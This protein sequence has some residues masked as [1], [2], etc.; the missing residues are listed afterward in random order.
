MPKRSHGSGEL[1]S[2]NLV[3]QVGAKCSNWE[4]NLLHWQH[5]SWH[6]KIAEALSSL[7]LLRPC[8]VQASKTPVHNWGS[9]KANISE[10]SLCRY[11]TWLCYPAVFLLWKRQ[12]LIKGRFVTKQCIFAG[13]V[14]T[15]PSAQCALD[16]CHLIPNLLTQVAD[17]TQGASPW[18]KAHFIPFCFPDLS[19]ASFL[20]VNLWMSFW[21]LCG[22]WDIVALQLLSWRLCFSY[23]PK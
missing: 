13:N 18:T 1:Q 21:S 17:P 2:R 3:A 15:S 22:S 19:D 7:D 11:E 8:W 12:R 9:D 5:R 16:S 4:L 20:L 10:L 14:I 6:L 23:R